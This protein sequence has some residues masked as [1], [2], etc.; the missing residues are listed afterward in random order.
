MCQSNLLL[1]LF[2]SQCLVFK[3]RTLNIYIYILAHY[4]CLSEAYQLLFEETGVFFLITVVKR[5]RLYYS[6][7]NVN[8]YHSSTPSF[9]NNIFEFIAKSPVPTKKYIYY[10]NACSLHAPHNILND[11]VVVVAALKENFIDFLW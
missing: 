7:K 2:N 6:F 3:T 8:E 1:F 11:F 10:V 9:I 5:F 4:H